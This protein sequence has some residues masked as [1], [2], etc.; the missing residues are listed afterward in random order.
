MVRLHTIPAGVAV[1]NK[2]HPE[3]RSWTS[4]GSI[5]RKRTTTI[6]RR[7]R[8]QRSRGIHSRIV[9]VNFLDKAHGQLVVRK[10]D[11]LARIDTRPCSPIHQNNIAPKTAI[12]VS[13]AALVV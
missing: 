4:P 11:M 13:A 7:S 9:E 1:F 12:S 10:P 5:A 3:A 2:S 8:N 6:L